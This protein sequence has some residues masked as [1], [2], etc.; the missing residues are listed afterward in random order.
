[1]TK[2]YESKVLASVHEACHSGL[3]SLR[4]L[5]T[6]SQTAPCLAASVSNATVLPA[7]GSAMST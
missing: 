4:K 7:P 2:Q 5:R 3:S 6:V 1:M